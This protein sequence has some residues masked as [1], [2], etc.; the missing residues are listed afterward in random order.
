MICSAL[1]K[2]LALAG[3]GYRWSRKISDRGRSDE[4]NLTA[5]IFTLNSEA[6]TLRCSVEKGVLEILQ[7]STVK[8]LWQSLLF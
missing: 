4:T 1:G 2:F 5:T 6:V 7:K 3:S 8:H